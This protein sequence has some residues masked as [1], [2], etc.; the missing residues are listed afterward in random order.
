M[1]FIFKEEN[2]PY[3]YE[4]ILHKNTYELIEIIIYLKNSFIATRWF[5]A[6]KNNNI[7]M[8]DDDFNLL[9]PNAIN[10]INRRLQLLAFH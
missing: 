7:I 9:T 8:C 3:Y 6:I 10:F 2:D 4:F 1:K 5:R